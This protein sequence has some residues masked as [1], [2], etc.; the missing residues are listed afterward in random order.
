MTPKVSVCCYT[1]NRAHLLPGMIESVLRQEGVELEILILD[2]ESEDG[3]Q[4]VLDQYRSDSRFKLFRRGDPH[5]FTLATGDYVC[6]LPDD[7]RLSGTFSL[8]HRAYVLDANRRLAFVFSSVRGHKEDGTDNGLL[9]MGR[10]SDHDVLT[11]A[12]PFDVLF[13]HCI[14]PWPSGMFRRSMCPDFDADYPVP[15]SSLSR[16]WFLWQRLSQIGDQ[17]YLADPTVTLCQHVGQ[18]S[19]Y[20]GI[21]KGGFLQSYLALWK[22]WIER[23]HTPSVAN[24]EHMRNSAKNVVQMQFGISGGGMLEEAYKTMDSFKP[25]KLK[26][27]SICLAMIA[28]NDRG[29][30][31]S[32]VIE[33]ALDSCKDLVDRSAIVSTSVELANGT[34]LST[35]RNWWEGCASLDG[36]IP[37]PYLKSVLWEDDYAKARN[38]ALELAQETGCDWIM[39]GLDCDEWVE[40][41]PEAIRAMLRRCK[42]DAVCL[43]MLTV[44]GKINPRLAFIR[45]IPGWRWEL[46]L[47]EVLLLNGE[48]AVA[49]VSYDLNNPL[50][51]PHIRTL[52]DG[53]RS[54]N[55]VKLEKDILT[56]GKAW[57]ETKLPR[58][59]FYLAESMWTKLR[60]AEMS[61]D[62]REEIVELLEESYNEY[63]AVESE[64]LGL[65]YHAMVELARFYVSQN[66]S[67]NALIYFLRA[68][69]LCPSRV[70]AVG[71]VA[72][73]YL[74][75]GSY[76]MAKIY[77]LACAH[78]PTPDPSALEYL[79]PE[80]GRWR[81]L[82]LLISALVN[83][84]QIGDA[85]QYASLVLSRSDLPDEWRTNTNHLLE[86][87]SNAH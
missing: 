47:H 57:E 83:L 18:Q 38:S 63:I 3:T 24:W 31:E 34:V 40:G 67:R 21:Q 73:L 82:V 81:G 79:E 12:A 48:R 60:T 49:E 2:D 36:N 17:A 20:E 39:V 50:S 29:S 7:D 4:A 66:D 51:G 64:P 75:T 74:R 23:G 85:R 87:M 9:Q 33:R 55:P 68:Y 62:E 42:T 71:E 32:H 15:G 10:V 46:V 65:R 13:L 69:S 26:D 80:W 56:L 76:S 6:S 22:Y 16:D 30:D 1:K 54:K 44:A 35:V 27:I 59:L 45:N 41:D 25:E 5:L 84:K 52:Q 43:P 78:T 53:A 86:E 58:Y 61:D 19:N 70:E 77:A 8:A 14:V 72:A 11:G 37:H 28:K